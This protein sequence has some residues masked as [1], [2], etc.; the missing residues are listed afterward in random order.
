MEWSVP[1]AERGRAV[2]TVPGCGPSFGVV[3]LSGSGWGYDT[4]WRSK[5][6]NSAASSGLANMMVRSSSWT[7]RP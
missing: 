2:R 3:F 4:G 5:P 7:I 6:R 1:C